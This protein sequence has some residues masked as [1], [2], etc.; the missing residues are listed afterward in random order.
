MYFALGGAFYNGQLSIYGVSNQT[1]AARL[2]APTLTANILSLAF[3]PN[4]AAI[5]AGEDAC[6]MVLVCN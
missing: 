5:I 1:E 3:T 4:G 6:G 2:A